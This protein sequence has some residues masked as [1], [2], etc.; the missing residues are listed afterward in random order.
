AP[1]RLPAATRTPRDPLYVS[2][3][4]L[5]DFRSWPDL[6]LELGPGAT[7]FVGRNGQGK[8][9]VVEAIDYL[10]RL[11]SHRVAGDTPLVRAGTEQALIRASV[12]KDGRPA[13]LEVE[14]NPGR[15]NRARIN[16]SPLPR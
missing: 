10:S 6:D 8:T 11:A 5:H 4:T 9:N 15:A 2:H 13:L 16:R 3:L 7:A 14:L 1:T 12:V